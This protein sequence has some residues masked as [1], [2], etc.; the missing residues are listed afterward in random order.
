MVSFCNF[1]EVKKAAEL[2]G[3]S[4]LAMDQG[5]MGHVKRKHGGQP[6]SIEG[7][8]WFVWRID[9]AHWETGSIEGVVGLGTG[10]GGSSEGVLEELSPGL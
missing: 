5:P 6:T 4:F 9:I 1:K 10:L 7:A 8:G 2:M 3:A